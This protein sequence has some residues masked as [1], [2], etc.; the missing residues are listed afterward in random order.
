MPS[1]VEAVVNVPRLTGVFH[2]HLPPELEGKVG[3][4]HLV[5]V[6]FGRQQVQ[7]VV[8]RLVEAPS[9]TSTRPVSALL[10]PAPVLTPAQIALA[11]ELSRRTLAPLAACVTLMLPPGLAQMVDT[12]YSL[13]P[14]GEQA[15]AAQADLTPAQV[16]LLTLLQRRG[17]LR[18]RQIERALPR[19]RW[20]A[21]ARALQRRGWLRLRP[22]LPPPS[23]RPKMERFV[24]L[25]APQPEKENLGR[26]GG[27]A[28]SRR[29]AMLQYMQAQHRPVPVRELYAQTDGQSADLRW[30]AKAGYIVV[31]EQQVWRDPLA[32]V[33]FVPAEPPRLTADQQ[34]V[35]QKVRAGLQRSAQG[36]KVAPFLLYGVTGSGKTEIYLRAVEETLRQGRQAI[37]LVPEIALTPQT[38]NRFVARFP[39]RV[40]LVHSRLSAGERYDTWRRARAGELSVVVGPRSALFTPFSRLGL[41]V[42]DECHDD[43]YY[44]SES[45]PHYHARELAALYARLCGA[46]CLMGSA[47]PDVVS[48]YRAARGEWTPLK[49]PER[50]LA[51]RSA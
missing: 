14:A 45:P 13:T 17:P 1:F 10:D 40:G 37:V 46:V 39:G 11:E 25:A 5:V 30:L 7:G 26:R 21:S 49:L 4:G 2:Y 31:F 20:Q 9:V 8:L 41:I 35:W 32:E 33:D 16:R 50:I 38:V 47:T 23:V 24:T 42:V 34:T 28:E 22:V 48:T 15:D 51:H 29:R 3:D 19:K 12:L 27:A 6:P 43:S 18:G 44:Q 36:E